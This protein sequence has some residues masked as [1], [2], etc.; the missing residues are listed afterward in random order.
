MPPLG[1]SLELDE[2]TTSRQFFISCTGFLSRDVST[3]SW[4][5]WHVSF[6]RLCPARHLCTWLTTYT[7]FRKVQDVGS[8]RPPTDR[9]LFHA[10]TSCLATEAGPRVWNS[11]P[12]HLRDE[13]ITV[14]H[15]SADTVVRAMNAFNGKCYFSGS[16]SSETF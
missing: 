4:H 2:G 5:Q 15:G 1:F 3:S 6:T 12:V 8:A 7:S 13:D 9:V 10:H 16:D 11:L 14:R